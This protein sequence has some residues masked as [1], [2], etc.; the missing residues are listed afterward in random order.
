MLFQTGEAWNPLL[1]NCLIKEYEKEI[2]SESTGCAKLRVFRELGYQAK[3]AG[4]I[5]KL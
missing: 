3:Q 4:W 5:G 1:T 2:F